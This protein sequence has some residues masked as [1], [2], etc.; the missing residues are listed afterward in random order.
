MPN[1]LTNQVIKAKSY[2]GDGV[3][4]QID[5]GGRL[6]LTTEDGIDTTNIIVLEPEVYDALTDFASGS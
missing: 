2:I 1:K 4:A 3:Y 6:V 5:A